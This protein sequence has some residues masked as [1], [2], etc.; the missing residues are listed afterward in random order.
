MS[1]AMENAIGNRSTKIDNVRRAIIFI[2]AMIWLVM[3]LYIVLVKPLPQMLQQPWHV[4]FAL[5]IVFMLKPLAYTKNG[6]PWMWVL[7]FA[8]F[9][10]LLLLGY[11][12]YVSFDRLMM[13]VP[14]ISPVYTYDKI[15]AVFLII[16]LLEAVR[17]SI[18]WTLL[19]VILF[20][21]SY[22]WWGQFITG[23]FKFLGGMTITT[24]LEMC[25]MTPDGIMGSIMSTSVT[26]IFYFF[27]FGAIFSASGA[28]DVLMDL[29]MKVGSKSANG[30]AAKVAVISSSFFGMASGSAVS[31]V[32]TTG[33]ITIPLMKKIGYTPEQAGAIEAA[34]SSGGQIMPPIMGTG[35]FIMAELLGV[36]YVRII[37]AAIIPAL[38]YYISLF[39]VVD[40]IA[41]KQNLEST[42]DGMGIEVPDGKQILQRIYLLLPVVILVVMIAYGRSLAS[43]AITVSVVAIIMA[44]L[45]KET[46]LSLRQWKDVVVDGIIS[47]AKL[48]VP[49]GAISL[50][51]GVISRSGATNKLAQLMSELGVS[52]SAIALVMAMLGCLVLGM[53]LPTVAAYI[54]SN[55]LFVPVLTSLGFAPLAANMF[56]FY[57]GIVAQI[58]PPV[59]MASITAAGIAEG[60]QWKTGWTAFFFALAAFIVPYMFVYRNELLLLGSIG[61]IIVSCLFLFLCMWALASGVTGYCFCRIRPMWRVVLVALTI[62]AIIPKHSVMLCIAA[63]YI[64]IFAVLYLYSLK[65]KKQEKPAL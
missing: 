32:T 50:M 7:D 63:V 53:A 21:I 40:F 16:V 31:N 41:R 11:Y 60:S 57:F 4:V 10:G 36:P 34:S 55:V 48:A 22:A 45:R 61:Q 5:I 2:T 14:I 33:V 56:I 43:S 8:V 3:Q 37:T 44:S 51:I 59:A 64:A 35:A 13:R 47:A 25:L 49:T 23:P 6:K 9:A 62:V 17:R 29:G 18:G 19:G 30:A 52:S 24:F 42:E 58:T 12:F 38:A 20:F 1:T 15:A 46:R 26:V 28:G 54:I 27:L 39:L 65:L